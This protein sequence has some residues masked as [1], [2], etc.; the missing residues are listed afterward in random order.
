MRI[1]DS[2]APGVGQEFVAVADQPPC[3]NMKLNPNTAGAMIHQIDHPSF[4]GGKLF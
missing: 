3:G 4:S 2:G 1:E